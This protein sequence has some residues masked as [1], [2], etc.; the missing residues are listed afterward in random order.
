LRRVAAALDRIRYAGSSACSGG[1]N[2]GARR[3]CIDPVSACI[4]RLGLIANALYCAGRTVRAHPVADAN[5]AAFHAALPLA[6]RSA[7]LR[8]VAAALRATRHA[9]TVTY[10]TCAD[11]RT[12]GAARPLPA[13]VAGFRGKG[14]AST[15][16]GQACA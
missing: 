1:A 3:T 14:I 5:A 10:A 4:A 9:N 2:I 12:A 11:E 6:V 13:C 8:D 15:R 16:T 7:C